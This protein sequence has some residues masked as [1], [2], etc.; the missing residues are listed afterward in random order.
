ML[1]DVLKLIWEFVLL[2]VEFFSEIIKILYQE[3]GVGFIILVA[4][5][6]MFCMIWVFCGLQDS[7]E[8]HVKYEN[9]KNIGKISNNLDKIAKNQK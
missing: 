1:F 4:V 3:F 8:E 9:F 7:Y 2:F 5:V 6:F